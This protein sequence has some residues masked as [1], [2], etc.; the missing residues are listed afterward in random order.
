M[1][2]IIHPCEVPGCPIKGTAS[3]M[4]N[5]KRLPGKPLVIV[6]AKH[7]HLA[8]KEGVKAY[9]LQATLNFQA[10]RAKE[11]EDAATFIRKHSSWT[12]RRNGLSQYMAKESLNK[13]R[14]EVQVE[15][16]ESADP[17]PQ[18]AGEGPRDEAGR[19]G[20]Q[21]NTRAA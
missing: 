7:A 10:A 20:L 16:V 14:R 1:E 4:W 2:N 19:E 15:K 11:R 12:G 17:P 3:K 13:L 18:K 5:L 21:P 8:R 9:N 6:C